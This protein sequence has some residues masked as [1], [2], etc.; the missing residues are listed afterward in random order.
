M[1]DRARDVLIDHKLGLGAT[2]PATP[3]VFLA[4]RGLPAPVVGNAKTLAEIDWIAVFADKPSRTTTCEYMDRHGVPRSV[5]K[6]V[7]V[8]GVTI[9]DRRTGTVIDSKEF[10]AIGKCPSTYTVGR[11]DI[12]IDFARTESFEQVLRWLRGRVAPASVATSETG[13]PRVEAR[14]ATIE[15]RPARPRARPA[16]R[17]RKA[18]HQISNLPGM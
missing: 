6:R 2:A 1:H 15:K 5:K 18:A 13:A 16:P 9:H 7:D 4:A 12:R 17:A 14:P 8:K 11:G 3:S 10:A